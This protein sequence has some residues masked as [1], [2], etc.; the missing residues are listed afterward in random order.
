[1]LQNIRLGA[2]TTK[3]KR[4]SWHQNDIHAIKIAALLSFFFSIFEVKEI[5]FHTFSV[6]QLINKNPTLPPD[7]AA[8][9]PHSTV[10][11]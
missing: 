9:L 4:K 6:N 7:A 3:K 10:R 5:F 2:K 8:S 11:A 1:M